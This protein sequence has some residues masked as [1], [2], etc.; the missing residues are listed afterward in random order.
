MWTHVFFLFSKV[1]S[2]SD[3]GDQDIGGGL[4]GPKRK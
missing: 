2:G 1:G 4:Q 3:V